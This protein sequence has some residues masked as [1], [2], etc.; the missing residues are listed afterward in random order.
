MLYGRCISNSGMIHDDPLL[1]FVVS[2]FA[3]FYMAYLNLNIIL[4]ISNSAPNDCSHDI[5]RPIIV[6]HRRTQTCLE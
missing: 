2:F 1:Y 6:P 4:P 3:I 5:K